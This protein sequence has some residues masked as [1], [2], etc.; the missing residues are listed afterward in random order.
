MAETDD[1]AVDHLLVAQD[2]SAGVGFLTADGS[3]GKRT[4]HALDL[5][6]KRLGCWRLWTAGGR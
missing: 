2:F 1:D 6:V 3:A 5:M 4:G